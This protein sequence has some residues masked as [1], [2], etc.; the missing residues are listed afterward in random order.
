MLCFPPG[1]QVVRALDSLDEFTDL[2]NGM[3]PG[4][5]SVF[6]S[7]QQ[8]AQIRMFR[9]MAFGSQDSSGFFNESQ[10]SWRSRDHDPTTVFSQN[11][12]GHG[13]VW[14]TW[15]TH[16]FFKGL[17][18]HSTHLSMH[19]LWCKSH[20]YYFCS[21]FP[22]MILLAMALCILCKLGYLLHNAMYLFIHV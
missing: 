19:F 20:F 16:S 17:H 1:S 3:K 22:N 14:V 11:K 2:N 18:A 21:H 8:S 6:D 10:S 4:Q 15:L 7:A 9:R 12:T 5:S 13:N